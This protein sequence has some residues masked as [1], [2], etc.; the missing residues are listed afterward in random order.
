MRSQLLDDIECGVGGDTCSNMT[1]EKQ[2]SDRVA[3]LD[4]KL[5]CK[6]E[7]FGWGVR[8]LQVGAMC[9][10]ILAL[11]TARSTI[12]V[13]ILAMTDHTRV[14]GPETFP[15]DKKIQGYILSAFFVG[16][17]LMQIP[18]GLM[19]KR[20]G[21]KPVLAFALVANGLICCT[22]PLMAHL[23][24]W[25]LVC[26]ARMLMGVTQ[27]CTL[28]SI[29]TLMG[30]WLP[31]HEFTT[32]SGIIHASSSIAVIISMP[33][34]GLLAE[35]ELGWK[36]I[37][38]VTAALLLAAAG[39]WWAL[40]ASSPGEHRLMTIEEKLYI[41]KDMTPVGTKGS[42]SVPW[43]DILRSKHVYAILFSNFAYSS[44]FSFLFLDMPTFMEKGLQLSLKN[45]AFLSAL[46]YTG[47][48]FSALF[49]T[50]LCDKLINNGYMSLRV[51]R[52][53]YNS[54]GLFGAAFFLVLLSLVDGDRKTLAVISLICIQSI[55]AACGAGYCINHLDLSPNY[56][57]VL[58]ALCNGPANIGSFVTPIMTS[59]I[60][61]NDPTNIDRW[62]VVCLVLAGVCA[63][64][65]VLYL[66]LGSSERQPWDCPRAPSQYC[67]PEEMKPLKKVNNETE[68]N[69]K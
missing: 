5:K 68:T 14:R 42:F 23:G 20:F 60:L 49:F 53:L 8:H 27:A 25:P 69:T 3:E 22:V 35:T 34:S 13:A 7:Q 54:L 50:F 29:H 9:L 15:W 33:I 2:A 61:Q 12:G 24:G 57:G 59:F 64:A 28:P 51:S 6:P 55:L 47:M 1:E 26:V 67:S 18:G 62:H 56:A 30:R 65:N 44:C 52:K 32:F 66:L 16:Y 19:A 17:A 40:A 63:A 38:Y 46:P 43:K 21:G 10:A 58:M 45:S 39:A 37:F 41:E 4:L 11:F 31:A 36:L 48:L